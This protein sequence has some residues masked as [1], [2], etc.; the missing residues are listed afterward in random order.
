MMGMVN[1]GCQRFYIYQEL[2]PYLTIYDLMIHITQIR[3]R[4]DLIDH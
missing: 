3:I 4:L 1:I 2:T